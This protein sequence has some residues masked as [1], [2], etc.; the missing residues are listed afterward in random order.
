MSKPVQAVWNKK[1]NVPARAFPNP[2]IQTTVCNKQQENEGRSP[3]D[4]ATFW[5]SLDNVP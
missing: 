3:K 5:Q 2:G 1:M 4:S